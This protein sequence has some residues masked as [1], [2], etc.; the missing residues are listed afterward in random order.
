MIK[1]TNLLVLIFISFSISYVGVHLRKIA[2]R[3]VAVYTYSGSWS[4]N[5]YNEKLSEFQKE[6]GKDNLVLRRN[7]IWIEVK[8]AQNP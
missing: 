1:M 8:S 5:R 4:E 6:V 7:E 3:T 2:P